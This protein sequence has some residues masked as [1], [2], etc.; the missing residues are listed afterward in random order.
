MMHL[1]SMM[2]AAQ[3]KEEE[4]ELEEETR[5]QHTELKTYYMESNSGLPKALE[6]RPL[7]IS[8]IATTLSDINVVR[9]EHNNRSAIFYLDSADP[10]FLL[11]YTNGIAITTDRLFKRL[12]DT[13]TNRFDRIWLPAGTQDEISHYSGNVSTGFGLRFEDLFEPENTRNLPIAELSMNVSGASSSRAF[14][15]LNKDESLK[16]TICYSK[17]RV[18]RG[19]GQ[20]Y[21]A[22]EI[23]YNGR[24]ITKNGE[25]IDDH[26]SLVEIVRKK[27]RSLIENIERNSLGTKSVDGRTLV[28]G[29]AFELELNREILDLDRFAERLADGDKPFRLWGMVNNVSRDMRQIIG[30]DLHTGDPINLEIMPSLIRV[31]IPRGGC[32]NTVLRLWVNLQHGFDSEIKLNGESDFAA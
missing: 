10:R 14:N 31:Y 27:Y 25:S 11:L 20:S 28:E 30:L 32:G 13:Q 17:I 16:Q 8:L 1:E 4:E 15:A 18:E 9:L 29:E 23:K 26:V 21:V 22:D 6:T 5:G 7:K 2:I 19:N 3:E 12:V 24:I